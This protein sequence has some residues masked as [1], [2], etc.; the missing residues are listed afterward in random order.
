M[1]WSIF[2][3]LSLSLSLYIYIYIYIY[4][5]LFNITVLVISFELRSLY[6]ILIMTRFSASPSRRSVTGT[7][8]SGVTY[9]GV[10]EFIYWG[11]PISNDKS[12]EKEIQ[13]G[14]LASNRTYFAAE[15]STGIDFYPELLKLY[16][17]RH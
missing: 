13:R 11:T 15:V 5:T 6:Q 4:I 8:I 9:E 10:A 1:S 14:V 16:Y 7:A 3:E 2:I 12:V 17:K